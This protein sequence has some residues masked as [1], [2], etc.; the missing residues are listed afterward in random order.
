MKSPTS[1]VGII[2]PEGIL[3]GSNRKER[4]TKTIRITGKKLA[5][6][7]TH[8][9]SSASLARSLRNLIT[10][11]AYKAPVTTSRT[12][13]INAKFIACIPESSVID[14][15]DSQ[16]GLLRNLDATHLLHALL[17]SLLLLQK[18]LLAGNVAAV[19]LGQHILAHRLD[20]FASND[21]RANSSLNRHVVHLAGNQFA[22][23][24]CQFA[25]TVLR[26]GAVYDQR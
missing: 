1:K 14:T 26:I 11:T 13:R 22:H 17:A 8:K 12:N 19:T 3:N 7:S 23:L 24:G 15:Q 9:G 20:V 4:S 25:A 2:E 21:V 18:L 16:E 10:S 5:P 6:H